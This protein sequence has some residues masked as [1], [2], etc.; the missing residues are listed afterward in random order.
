MF[1]LSILLPPAVI[2][3]ILAFLIYLFGKVTTVYSPFADDR[4]LKIEISGV[5]FILNHIITPAAGIFFIYKLGIALINYNIF[6]FFGNL[7]L[8]FIL[9]VIVI[10]IISSFT[11]IE[12][13]TNDFIYEDKAITG[14]K[15]Y[16]LQNILFY[17]FTM[18]MISLIILLNKQEEFLY[19]ILVIMYLFIHLL[20]LAIFLSL[21]NE[22]I[23]ITNI[24]FITSSGEKP[25]KE[26]RILKVNDDNVRIIKN[27]IAMIINK[28]QIL[29]I[30]EKRNKRD[31]EKEKNNQLITYLNYLK[32]K[33]K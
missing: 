25:I 7:F 24:Y 28:S 31:L 3:S 15:Y 29:R 1:D 12:K 5:S 17:L 16:S 27:N 19:A 10:I 21:K 32:E 26:C 30:E 22:N 4:K 33:I 6:Q 13:R 18:F 11:L 2:V 9:L 23:S 14:D 8:Q 20:G